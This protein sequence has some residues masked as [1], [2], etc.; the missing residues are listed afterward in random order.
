MQWSTACPDW[1]RRIV[2]GESLIPFKPLFPDE[3]AA[4]R[5]TLSGLRIVD[6]AGSP[7]F[8]EACRPWVFEFS[9][10]VFGSYDA[11]SGR[12]LIREFLLLVSKKNSKSTIAA[13][14]MVTALLRNWRQSCEL[15]ILAPTLEIANNSFQPARDM[16]RA[17][18]DLSTM[19][20][21]QE[22][23]RT[24]RHRRTGATLKVI[25]ADSETVSGKKAA[26]VLVDE[27]W[28]F[29]KRANA[30]NMLREVTGGLASRPEG[31]V[32][33]LSTQ[34]DT[35]PAGIWRQKLN[36]FRDVRDGRVVNKRAL[37]VLYEYPQAMLDAQDYR[38]P[39]NFYI[40]NPN[41]GAS[42]DVEF[43][44]GELVKA[45]RAG[46]E[47]LCGFAAKHLNVEIGLALRSDRWEG[48]DFWAENG[49]PGLTLE[50]LLE[51]SD[52]VVVGI[53]GGGLDDLLGLAVLGRDAKTRAWLL[54][55]HAWCHVKVLELRAA[56]AP[57]LRDFERAGSLTIYD[58]PGDD[59]DELVE[60]VQTVAAS[61]KLP[62]K[63]GIGVDVIAI[64]EIVDGLESVGI[65]EGN[66]RVAGIGQGWKLANTIK[67]TARRL[68][69]GDLKHDGSALMKW[70]VG[71][72]KV[73]P[74]GNAVLIT[75]QTAGTGKIDPLMAAFNA[76]SLMARNPGPAAAYIYRDDRE[77]RVI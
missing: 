63:H 53:D 15:L 11:D 74:R 40:T 2:A 10:A 65:S 52:V 37:G 58:M 64:S 28:L 9:D 77:L 41:L 32:I 39:D 49:E 59:V 13:A 34:A 54:W 44:E 36:E 47:S 68:A 7:T 16:V 26:F 3:A 66:E 33:Y 31:F 27:L 71:N 18:P 43:L 62:A 8:G 17:D 50:T 1:E 5:E 38:K 70:V 35:A 69:A 20:H 56:M 12:R 24:I 48:A 29:G 6:A 60:I 45:E 61:G 55:C 23:L 25:A 22:H 76:V 42:V 67:T 57:T 30:E 75:K 73:E 51:R 46:A 14:I 4:A 72:A 19:L 21:V